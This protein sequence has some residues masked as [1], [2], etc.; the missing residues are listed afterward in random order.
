MIPWYESWPERWEDELTAL[1]NAGLKYEL[2][3]TSNVDGVKKLTVHYPV[4]D[5]TLILT[6]TYP[7]LYPYF[8]PE[9]AAYDESFLK[10]QHPFAKNLCLLG[11]ST[12]YWTP[13]QTL[14]DHL[15]EQIP[16]LLESFQ[17]EKNSPENEEQQGEPVSEFLHYPTAKNAIIKFN[18]VIP[19][20]VQM[21]HFFYTSEGEQKNLFVLHSL[22]FEMGG[23]SHRIGETNSKAQSAIWIK[24]PDLTGHG[25]SLPSTKNISLLRSNSRHNR[26]GAFLFKEEVTLGELKDSLVLIDLPKPKKGRRYPN[27][28]RTQRATLGAL[29]ERLPHNYLLENKHVIVIGLGALGA[30]AAIEIA[31]L[32]PAKLT[33]VDCD[34][35]DVA[36]SVRWPL[37]QSVA[38]LKKVDAI[39]RFLELNFPSVMTNTIN[40][41]M[42]NIA[43]DERVIDEND[44]LFKS[45]CSADQV[46]S[47]TAEH[48][49]N[50]CLS[51]YCKE[52]KIIFSWAYAHNGI[53]GG[54]V[55]IQPAEPQSSC[56]GCFLHAIS[57]GRLQTPP[58]KKEYVQPEGCAH[59]TFVG[60]NLENLQIISECIRLT[61][62][63]NN[64]PVKDTVIRSVAFAN[65]AGKLGL[66]E[67]SEALI[68]RKKDCCE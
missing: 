17:G 18:L 35:F 4:P 63:K 51:R 34:H 12:H 57:D 64:E 65:S 6:A 32:S 55:G 2:E 19:E 11:R 5:R 37:G 25:Q 58:E 66:P 26:I 38:G 7:P 61:I 48:G 8:R 47:F 41:R 22:T 50:H 39:S 3:L 53:Y 60:S 9:V 15:T 13:D 33:L 52:H 36:Q 44:R 45:I 21:G 62:Q 20:A 54:V 56:Y 14:A 1:Q 30:Q 24:V 67:W 49:V 42:G 16:L 27:Y 29:N 31:K 43:V 46:F 40:T 23:T 28:V 10:H 59:L 68:A